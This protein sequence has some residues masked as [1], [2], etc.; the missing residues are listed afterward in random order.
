M[1]ALIV[2]IIIIKME[3]GL[4]NLTAPYT[5]ASSQLQLN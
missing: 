5:S 2:N 4:D 3:I 1:P